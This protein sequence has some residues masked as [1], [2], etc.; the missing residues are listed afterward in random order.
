MR[1][2]LPQIGDLS[3]TK[4]PPL[5]VRLTNFNGARHFDVNM[6]RAHLR[7]GLAGEHGRQTKPKQ[8]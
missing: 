2:L 5:F 8:S 3:T 4:L 6:L 7:V 1:L